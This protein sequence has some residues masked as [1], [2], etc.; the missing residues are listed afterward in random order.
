MEFI[1]LET[2]DSSSNGPHQGELEETL[3]PQRDLHSNAFSTTPVNQTKIISNKKMISFHLAL[4]QATETQK[5]KY[6]TILI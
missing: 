6:Q 2:C 3:K 1:E 4:M 5:S